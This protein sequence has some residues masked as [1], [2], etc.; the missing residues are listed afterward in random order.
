VKS[1][2]LK[3]TLLVIPL[4]AVAREQC[5]AHSDSFKDISFSINITDIYSRPISDVSVRILKPIHKGK[6]KL[7]VTG[8]TNTNGKL[9]FELKFGFMREFGLETRDGEKP[10]T[11]IQ[12]FH[13]WSD[14][15]ILILEKDKYRDLAIKLNSLAIQNI[16]G[17]NEEVKGVIELVLFPENL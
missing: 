5:G 12:A 6:T 7:K 8:T 13:W 2:L 1:I 14:E 17:L 4:S 15:Y 16:F 9:E 10:C 11:P 3:L